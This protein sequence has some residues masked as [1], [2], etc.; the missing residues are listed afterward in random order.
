MGTAMPVIATWLIMCC[1]LRGIEMDDYGTDLYEHHVGTPWK[2]SWNI[3]WDYLFDG[4][5]WDGYCVDR[6]YGEV[7]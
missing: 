2:E 3:M 4:M 7:V 5:L 6:F 1:V